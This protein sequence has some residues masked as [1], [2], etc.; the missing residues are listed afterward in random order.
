MFGFTFKTLRLYVIGFIILLFILRA[1]YLGPSTKVIFYEELDDF[2]Y[3]FS[4]NCED[5]LVRIG[6]IA[7]LIKPVLVVAKVVDLD[8]V[9]LL[10]VIR[11]LFL[12]IGFGKYLVML[13]LAGF[14]LGRILRFQAIEDFKTPIILKIVGGFSYEFVTLVLL[15]LLFQAF[16]S[17]AYILTFFFLF[18]PALCGIRIGSAC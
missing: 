7:D 17:C 13:T 18:L 10:P 2:C 14:A 3:I 4:H 12:A 5:A 9:I 16:I 15:L 11:I 6:K 1:D 8:K